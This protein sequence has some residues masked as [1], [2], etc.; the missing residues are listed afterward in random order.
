[1]RARHGDRHQET[2]DA[3]AGL[4]EQRAAHALLGVG[5]SSLMFPGLGGGASIWDGDG[6]DIDEEQGWKVA[7]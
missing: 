7:F 5:T 1:M 2:L 6:A 4:I 3:I